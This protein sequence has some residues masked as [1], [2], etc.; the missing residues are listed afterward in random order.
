MGIEEQEQNGV[1]AP[2]KEAK[3]FP[4][5]FRLMIHSLILLGG[6]NDL[7]KPIIAIKTKI[8][9]RILRES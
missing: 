9:R 8:S 1:N 7:K 2:N 4:N 3:K 6:K 5:P